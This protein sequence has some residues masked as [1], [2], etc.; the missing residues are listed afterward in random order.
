MQKA[1]H[2]FIAGPNRP[3]G[4][5]LIELL[6]VIAVLAV[7]A[8][9]AIPSFAGI[10]RQY[11]VNAAVDE[12]MASVQLARVDAMRLG[13][14]ILIQRQTSCDVVLPTTADWDC[15]W[16]VFVDLN[17]NQLPD[18]AEAELQSVA[19]P[20]GIRLVKAKGGGSPQYIT[21]NR[22]GQ[23]TAIG[24]RFAAFPAG[25]DDL[26]GQLICFSTGTRLRTVKGAKTCPDEGK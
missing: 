24:Q 20:T 8:S 18:P 17:G 21:I 9:I 7:L 15:G 10:A 25:M 2:L 1:R 19:L 16:R 22:Y 4:V 13:Q 26:S 6:V 5:S 11:R 3:L 14:D 12:F 23:V